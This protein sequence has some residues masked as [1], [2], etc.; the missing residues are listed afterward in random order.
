MET[1]ILAV[2]TVDS[3]NH[4]RIFREDKAGELKKYS[5][6]QLR[7]YVARG[8]HDQVEAMIQINLDLLLEEGEA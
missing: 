2:L 6:N 1:V 5:V 8:E 3:K 7:S 4:H